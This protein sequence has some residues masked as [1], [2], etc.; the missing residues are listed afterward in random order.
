MTAKQHSLIPQAGGLLV[1]C[2]P[3]ELL[4]RIPDGVVQAIYLDP[5]YLTHL[6][7][8][9]DRDAPI[10][11]YKVMVEGVL[12]QAKR[13]LAKRGNLFV[14]F[15]ARDEHVDM[16]AALS[17]VFD[18]R[19]PHQITI[20][21]PRRVVSPAKG[22][23]TDRET[24][25]L[26]QASDESVYNPILLPV[27]LQG[28]VHTDENGQYRWES[29]ETSLIGS[30][31]LSLEFRGVTPS[32]GRAWRFTPAR[33]EE[34][35]REGKIG[36]MDSGRWGFKRYAADVQPADT[37]LDWSDIPP[38]TPASEYLDLNGERALQ[39]PL[40]LLDRIVRLGSNAGD[41]V[42][43]LPFAESGTGAVACH[44]LKRPWVSTVTSERG[45]E[46]CKARLEREGAIKDTDFQI[47][48]TQTVES[49]TAFDVVGPPV[50][51]SA[52]S[53]LAAARKV[54]ALE[55]AIVGAFHSEAEKA[56]AARLLVHG[57]FAV[58]E[59][60]TPG[61]R[62]VFDFFLPTPPFGVVEVKSRVA[63]G[64][65]Q[66]EAMLSQ[67]ATYRAQLGNSARVYIADLESGASEA[68]LG[69]LP[70][71]V[72]VVGSESGGVDAVAD[73][74]AADFLSHAIQVPG[75]TGPPASELLA[76]TNELTKP[77]SQQMFGLDW[78]MADEER[79]VL[80]HEIAHLR[81][82]IGHEH[83]T[84][85][86]LR[87]GRSVEFIIYAACRSWG[88]PVREPLLLGLKKLDDRYR[89]LKNALVT[90]AGVEDS[91]HRKEQAEQRYVDATTGLQTV[92][93]QI[94][95][96][97][98]QHTV[99]QED[100]RKSPV[101]PRALLGDIQ[102]KFSR[103]PAVREAVAKAEK[104]L[105]DLLELRNA[106]AHASLEGQPREVRRKE[107]ATMID[108][109]SQVLSQLQSCRMAIEPD[110]GTK[111]E[112]AT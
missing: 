18:A 42:V 67:V 53:M 68:W 87:V 94:M 6:P 78:L 25:F 66:L 55:R 33:M 95:R 56:L 30:A 98:D 34:L 88:V 85:A 35:A 72:V 49:C 45:L 14:R 31:N 24:I 17:Q 61:S 99:A 40:E 39:E 46:F 97:L 84:A 74:I 3:L 15:S 64:T 26:A 65:K 10:A 7:K 20:A 36:L 91:A 105:D 93:N 13:V 2:E 47:V 52:G 59:F 44:R 38:R 8:G 109:L 58:H 77:L 23:R 100:D 108:L 37:A 75:R 110:R 62:Y 107:L 32:K 22:P 101:N 89:A 111:V 12:K 63:G 71:G 21:K 50:L 4:S 16:N 76:D 104:P 41:L 43:I 103:I 27:E 57:I 69:K 90:Y 60:R 70:D 102:S 28:A 96:K 92:L 112:V 81:D 83:F 9:N 73:L 54:S 48:S 106:A 86:A 80:E 5:P 51:L 1:E 19:P 29:L 82:E 79:K 11:A